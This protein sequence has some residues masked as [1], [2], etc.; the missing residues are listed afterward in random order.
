MNLT[1]EQPDFTCRWKAWMVHSF[2]LILGTWTDSS[3]SAKRSCKT[4]ENNI[5]PNFIWGTTAALF[6]SSSIQRKRQVCLWHNQMS[7]DWPFGP[8]S[9]KQLHKDP[10]GWK[11]HSSHWTPFSFNDSEK[12]KFWY[13]LWTLLVHP[14]LLYSKI[15]SFHIVDLR[16]LGVSR[17]VLL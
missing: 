15:I 17:Q 4:G 13:W 8:V 6:L 16:K 9:P 10:C 1:V 7:G 2:I 12:K 5:V 11:F 3:R 14:S